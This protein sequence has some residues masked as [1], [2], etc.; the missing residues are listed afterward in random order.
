MP[1]DRIGC[2]A[3]LTRIATRNPALPSMIVL[4][5]GTL[6]RS[7]EVEPALH[8]W[9]RRKQAWLKIDEAIPT[10]DASPAP[11]EFAA[12]VGR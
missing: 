1:S 6:D 4:R 10:F 11:A 8:I 9:T 7:D 12:A 3:C 5:V 2:A